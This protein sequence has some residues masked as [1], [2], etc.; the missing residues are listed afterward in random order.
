ML[1]YFSLLDCIFLLC[2]QMASLHM[3]FQNLEEFDADES[4]AEALRLLETVPISR[5]LRDCGEGISFPEE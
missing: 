5:L 1:A 4:C 3:M 2:V